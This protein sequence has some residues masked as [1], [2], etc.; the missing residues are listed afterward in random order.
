[1]SGS[2]RSDITRQ[3]NPHVRRRPRPGA[4]QARHR[5]PARQRGRDRRSARAAAGRRGVRADGARARAGA[6]GGAEPFGALTGGRL[7]GRGASDMKGGVA[8]LVIAAERVAALG[9]GAAGLELVLTAAEETGCEGARHLAAEPDLL[10]RVGAVL[11]AEPTGGVPHVG[12][13]GVLFTPASTEG[14]SA[15]GSAPHL[16]RN[17][18]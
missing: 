7:Y 8:A 9:R 15:H 5:Q 1:M 11:V 12:H 2:P 18:I 16:G 3:T 6:P 10:G 14:V 13:K 4:D 17:A